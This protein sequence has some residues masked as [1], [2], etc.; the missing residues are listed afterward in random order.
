M[1]VSE[2]MEKL[3]D[4]LDNEQKAEVFELSVLM[5]NNLSL[6]AMKTEDYSEAAV[7]AINA[8]RL[9]DALEAK[10]G[11]SSMVFDALVKRSSSITDVQAMRKLWKKKSLF[12]AGKA[13]LKR[14]NYDEAVKNLDEAKQIIAGDMAYAKEEEEITM[15]LAHAISGKKAISV[16]EKK[17]YRKAFLTAAAESDHTSSKSRDPDIEGTLNKDINSEKQIIPMKIDDDDDDA[18]GEDWQM[19]A[20]LATGAVAAL[21]IGLFFWMRRRKS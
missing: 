5:N 20:L 3:G 19:L 14:K 8:A 15:L 10:I 2:Q 17:M 18:N 16:K 6:C 4:S 1:L 7:Y 9:I 21:S 11:S 13:E 12:L